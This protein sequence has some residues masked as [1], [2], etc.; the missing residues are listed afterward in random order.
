MDNYS[1]DE[2]II[3]CVEK[4]SLLEKLFNSN[5]NLLFQITKNN[6]N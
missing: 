1:K 6:V 3:L 5:E 2:Q 4:N